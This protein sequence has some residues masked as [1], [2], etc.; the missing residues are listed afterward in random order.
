M[1]LVNHTDIPD[2]AI[3]RMVSFCV[4]NIEDLKLKHVRQIT[5][6]NRHKR[7]SYSGHYQCGR[8]VIAIT[9]PVNGR[10]YQYRMK[11][12]G[13]IVYTRGWEPVEGDQRHTLKTRVRELVGVMA[14]ELAHCM[15]DVCGNR[16]RRNGS[17]GGSEHNTMWFQRLVHRLYLARE[18]EL[19]AEWLGVQAEPVTV[20]SEAVAVTP[21]PEPVT[22]AI[23]AMPKPSLAQRNLEKNRRS[24]EQWE[25]KLARAQRKTKKLRA[26]IKAAERRL[27][28]K[29][30]S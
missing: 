22:T 29:E 21:E 27:N 17:P 6:R 3:R 19:L 2:C 28:K 12:T 23:V 18:D 10:R 24:L 1:I 15:F 13:P 5:L 30:E 8:R 20:P 14:H 9:V 25:K 16:S 26:K 11:T 4:R 7:G